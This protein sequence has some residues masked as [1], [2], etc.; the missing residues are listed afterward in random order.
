MKNINI[1]SD[2]LNLAIA[3]A[4][5]SEGSGYVYMY[6]VPGEDD[7]DIAR[8]IDQMPCKAMAEKTLIWS[9]EGANLEPLTDW[10][11]ACEAAEQVI[12]NENLLTVA[13]EALENA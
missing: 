12:I 10:C 2:S 1:D 8:F 9:R 13:R 7:N 4:C 5:Y 6:T 3:N 11:D